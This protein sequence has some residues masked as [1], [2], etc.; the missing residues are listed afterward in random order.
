MERETEMR[1]RKERT[2]GGR[3]EE[4]D[5]QRQKCWT[6]TSSFKEPKKEPKTKL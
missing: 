3:S 1:R 6:W 2:V 4:E 5:W